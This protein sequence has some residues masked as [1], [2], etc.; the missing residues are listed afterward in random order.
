MTEVCLLLEIPFS[1]ELHVLASR[2]REEKKIKRIKIAM[3]EKNCNLRC[4]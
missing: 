1:I 2:V 4:R 3:E